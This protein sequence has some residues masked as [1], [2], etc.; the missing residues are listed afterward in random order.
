LVLLQFEY[1]CFYIEEQPIKKCMPDNKENYLDIVITQYSTRAAE[2][3]R[4]KKHKKHVEAT[5]KVHKNIR[6]QKQTQQK[7]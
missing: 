3:T 1:F 6:Q 2:V 7:V 5:R 4:T